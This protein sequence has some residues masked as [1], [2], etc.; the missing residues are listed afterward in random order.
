MPDYTAFGARLACDFA[1]PEL[2]P[3]TDANALGWRVETRRCT[4]PALDWV[5]IGTDTVYGPVRVRAFASPDAFRLAFDDT[6]TFDVHRSERTIAWY[7]G[8]G[9][10]DGAVRADLLGRVMALVAHADGRLALHASAVS[11]G[12]RAIAFLGPKHAG[13]STLALA[14]V[15]AGARLL[16]DDTLVVRVPDTGEAWAAPGVQRVRLWG[17]SARALRVGG[18]GTAAARTEQGGAK[19][20]LDALPLRSLEEH[21]VPLDACYVLRAVAPNADAVDDQRAVARSPMAGVQAALAC[22]QFA[23]LGALAGGSEGPVVLDR[24]VRLVGRADIYVADVR[25]DLARLDDVVAQLVAW[26]SPPSPLSS[27]AAPNAAAG[28]S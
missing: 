26:H 1:L 27:V 23:K 6:G 20:T 9:A 14:L 12:G 28:R 18:R 7:P 21:E 24:A 11:L 5:P 19:P 3:A 16:T 13:K 8:E 10:T 2:S 22:V 25:R 4:P 15:R 17:D